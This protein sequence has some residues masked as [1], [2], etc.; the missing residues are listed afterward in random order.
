MFRSSL[1]LIGYALITIACMLLYIPTVATAQHT[2]P[3][4]TAF[5]GTTGNYPA[6]VMIAD[7]SGNLYGVTQ[8]GG[9]DVYGTV[10]E[11]SLVREPSLALAG[12]HVTAVV[13]ARQQR[14]KR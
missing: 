1:T 4:L 12:C 13:V 14:L 11:L 3:T 7:A 10:S 8:I 9:D 6:A 2:L 5:D